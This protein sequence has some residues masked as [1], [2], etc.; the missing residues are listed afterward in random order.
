M[1]NMSFLPFL[2]YNLYSQSLGEYTLVFFTFNLQNKIT[3]WVDSVFIPLEFDDA[4][5]EQIAAAI[6]E[7][8][9][10]IVKGL[11]PDPQ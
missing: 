11:R 2:L 9:E 4:Q 10:K 8:R 7:D 5:R 6:Y 3:L 1:V